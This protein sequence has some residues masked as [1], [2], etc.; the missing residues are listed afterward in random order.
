[1]FENLPSYI[2]VSIQIVAI[3]GAALGFFY[4][5]RNDIGILRID[6]VNIKENQKALAE[7]FTQLG[8]ILTKVAVQDTRLA[9]MEKKLD[10]LSHG[11]GYVQSR[12]KI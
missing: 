7:A 10:E 3:A 5:L 9:M 6:I 12:I 4:A 8:N 2:N 1:M 11:Q